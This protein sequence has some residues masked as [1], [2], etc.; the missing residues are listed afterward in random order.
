MLHFNRVVHTPLC[1]LR[2]MSSN[3]ENMKTSVMWDR[4]RGIL[5][6][7]KGVVVGWSECAGELQ[8]GVTLWN[9]LPKV[10]YVKFDTTHPFQIDGLSEPNVYP[11]CATQ[12]TWFLDSKRARP[13]LRIRRTQ[14]PLAPGFAITAHV[15]QGQTILEGV[16]TDLCLGPGAN[17]FTAYVA[18]TRI[19]GREWL[20]ILRPFPAAPFQKGIG[21]G[22][23]LLLRHLR[24]DSIHW[25]ALLEKYCEE[26]PCSTCNERK[27]SCALT[28]GQWKRDDKD[29]VCRECIQHYAD[30][31]TPWQCNVCKQW[32]VEENFPAKHRQRQCSFYRVCLTCEAK[33][34]CFACKVPKPES[35]FGP[36]AWKSRHADRRICKICAQK[37]R[38]SWT[39][40][41]CEER[42]LQEEF[43]IWRRSHNCGPNGRQTCDRCCWQVRM[44]RIAAATNTR[45]QSLREKLERA[46]REKIL[47]AV[48]QDIAARCQQKQPQGLLPL[49]PSCAPAEAA[50]LPR[51]QA[52]FRYICPFCEVAIGSGVETGVV[53]HRR[54]CGHQFRVNA[55][56]VV[57]E[58]YSHCCPKCG[59]RVFSQKPSGRIQIPHKNHKG[60]TCSCQSWQA[61]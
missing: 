53:D 14:F 35:D 41:Q 7:C 32:H 56:A 61:S 34:P 2:T 19:I 31:G 27:Q 43:S 37:I 58:R 45:V 9:N 3:V 11:V 10:V 5:R 22:R 4:R 21:L 39:C 46:R 13:R 50:D 16:L 57:Q 12:R 59:V 6:G 25:K 20:L 52:I 38:G 44:R 8:G 26:R 17:P 51:K 40:A 55:G 15:A 36:A 1:A 42:K 47:A 18:F 30:A 24:G 28:A 54:S 48:W 29:R 60:K 33:K 23:D 49:Q